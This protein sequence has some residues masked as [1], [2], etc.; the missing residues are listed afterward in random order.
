MDRSCE[1]YGNITQCQGGK[2]Y[3][4]YNKKVKA[5]WIGHTLRRNCLPKHV[6]EGK[7]QERIQMMGR[8]DK[9]LMQLLDDL[10]EMSGYNNLKEKVLD[11][12]LWRIN[13]GRSYGPVVRHTKQ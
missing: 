9:R 13:F 12:T 6:T 4:T 3:P 2:E 1:K 5:Y 8:R 11:R 7:I 10:K